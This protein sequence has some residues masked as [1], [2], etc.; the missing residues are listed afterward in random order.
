MPTGEYNELYSQ[1]SQM[2]SPELQPYLAAMRALDE[3]MK[4][5]YR[6]AK[7]LPQPVILLGNFGDPDLTH[8][9]IAFRKL[10]GGFSCDDTGSSPDFIGYLGISS[11]K[12]GTAKETETSIKRRSS[13]RREHPSHDIITV[14]VFK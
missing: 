14:E 2:Q 8:P 1:L 9:D 10:E 11:D 5:L 3:Q 7:T 13:K 6:C 4:E 12:L